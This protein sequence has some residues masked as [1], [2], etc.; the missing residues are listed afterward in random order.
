MKLREKLSFFKVDTVFKLF[1]MYI[2]SEVACGCSKASR[3]SCSSL[4]IAWLTLRE[5]G[6]DIISI[7]FPLRSR[8]FW[9]MLLLSIVIIFSDWT[10]KQNTVVSIICS[11]ARVASNQCCINLKEF[12][13]VDAQ[14][15]FE[16][17]LSLPLP[18]TQRER[19]ILNFSWS[20]PYLK[21]FSTSLTSYSSASMYSP[22]GTIFAGE[23]IDTNSVFK[24]F[25]MPSCTSIYIEWLALTEPRHSI[26][27]LFPSRH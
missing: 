5:P 20:S 18:E 11:N 19:G 9:K 13:R 8:P 16:V 15:K 22:S 17:S 2:C 25:K 10:R 24:V 3:T 14:L 7:S 21:I 6:L 23:M 1:R 12:K 27:F 26:S 4:C